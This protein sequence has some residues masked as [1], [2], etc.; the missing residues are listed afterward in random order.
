MTLTQSY[1]CILIRDEPFSK[2]F[3]S[4]HC[5]FRGT[6]HGHLPLERDPVAPYQF[7][8]W[9]PALNYQFFIWKD[10]MAGNKVILS[11]FNVVPVVCYF[12]V[13][14]QYLIGLV[15]FLVCLFSVLCSTLFLSTPLRTLVCVLYPSPP[16]W[17]AP[18][19][20]AAAYEVCQKC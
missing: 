20:A 14:R 15:G 8:V 16:C 18:E 10:L 3:V 13:L 11:R 19:R 2:D 1:Y 9:Q 4:V 17:L 7:I 5:H 12:L 6:I